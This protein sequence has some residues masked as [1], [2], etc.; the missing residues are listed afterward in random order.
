MEH[1]AFVFDWEAFTGEL[2]KIL[3]NA[4]LTNNSEQLVSFIKDNL[5]FIKDPCEGEPL[6]SEWEAGMELD[7]VHQWGDLALT[8]FYNPQ[9]DIGLGYGWENAQNLILEEGGKD[10]ALLGSP[11]GPSQNYFDAGKMGS[12]FQSA[13]QVQEILQWLEELQQKK[14]ALFPVLNDALKMLQKAA[15]VNKGIYVTF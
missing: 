4:L 7:D 3:E 2:S 15:A 1:K 12:Y 14:P 11:F 8:K 6:D 13:S 9:D 5:E 10:C